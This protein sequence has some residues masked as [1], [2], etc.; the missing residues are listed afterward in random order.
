MATGP[1][2]APRG[3]SGRAFPLGVPPGRPQ[4]GRDGDRPPGGA[5]GRSPH[6]A[7]HLTVARGSRAPRESPQESG[8]AAPEPAAAPSGTSRR[9][10]PPAPAALP[11]LPPWPGPPSAAAAAGAAPAAIGLKIASSLPLLSPPLP[12]AQA[13]A[14][15]APCP[16]PGCPPPPLPSRCPL[17]VGRP[18][19]GRE[20]ACSGPRSSAAAT[21]RWPPGTWASCSSPTCPRSG[22]PSQ[23]TGSTR[24]SVPSPTT[25]L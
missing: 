13:P 14:A 7:C 4:A 24:R 22:C 11:L 9:R 12:R 16:G 3:A 15:A 21:R 23:G 2:Q 6:A 17:A 18:A 10:A 25:R 20:R 8:P 19:G 5:A 1:P